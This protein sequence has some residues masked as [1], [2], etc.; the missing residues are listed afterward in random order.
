[1][2]ENSKKLEEKEKE[3]KTMFKSLSEVTKAMYGKEL[4]NHEKKQEC[5]ACGH[6]TFQMYEDYKK[7][8]C[9]HPSCG[10]HLNLNVII[11]FPF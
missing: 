1:M 8:K 11:L 3:N 2:Y 5:P 4:E 9:F 10:L 6:K 7:A